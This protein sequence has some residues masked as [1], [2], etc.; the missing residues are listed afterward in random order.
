[1]LVAALGTQLFCNFHSE[2]VVHSERRMQRVQP[3]V[4]VHG[5]ATGGVEAVGRRRAIFIWNNSQKTGHVLV[6][7]AHQ[8][9]GYTVI[10]GILVS[11]SLLETTGVIQH[12]IPERVRVV[13]EDAGIFMCGFQVAGERSDVPIP[14]C[15]HFPFRALCGAALAFSQG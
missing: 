14:R 7:L 10:R 3:E 12:S 11:T 8:L 13:E 9:T 2:D 5:D 4:L 15:Y 1:M 6:S